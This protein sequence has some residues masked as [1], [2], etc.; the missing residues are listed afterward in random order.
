MSFWGLLVRYIVLSVG[1]V[2]I[3]QTMS[4]L[5]GFNFEATLVVLAGLAGIG[6]AIHDI[7]KEER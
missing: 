6:F 2:A 1:A 5:W 4:F 7:R 3:S